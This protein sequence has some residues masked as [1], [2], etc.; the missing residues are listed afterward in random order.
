[1]TQ[2]VLFLACQ[3]LAPLLVHLRG[4]SPVALFAVTVAV[5][6]VFGG[7]N[8]I[9]AQQALS[10]IQGQENEY[11][12]TYYVVGR[13]YYLLN[14]GFVMAFFAVVTWLQTRFGA[15]L[16]PKITKAL[17]WLF[18]L[19][20]MGSSVSFTILDL[21]PKPRRYIDYPDSMETITLI[22]SW[23]AFFSSIA[24]IGLLGLLVLSGVLA[25]RENRKNRNYP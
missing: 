8:L 16:F 3:M 23:A 5:Y 11:Q 13:G 12:D 24:V 17:F 25:W 9:S 18:H 20:L 22:I 6:A 1:M 2:S 15:M 10:N 19:G 14:I 4:W 21:L 7:A